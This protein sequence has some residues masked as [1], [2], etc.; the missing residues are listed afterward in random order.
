M[1]PE[2][3]ITGESAHFET[4]GASNTFPPG[5]GAG[6]VS[7]VRRTESG[8]TRASNHV[9]PSDTVPR[10]AMLVFIARAGY[11]GIPGEAADNDQGDKVPCTSVG[12]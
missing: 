3:N 7:T 9:G 11:L 10:R 4:T 12:I 6:H 2:S 8:L 1:T 5:W